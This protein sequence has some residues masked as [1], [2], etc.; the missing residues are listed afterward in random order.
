MSHTL[1]FD[2]RVE[3]DRF[4]VVSRAIAQQIKLIVRETLFIRHSDITIFYSA[5]LNS[6]ISR[7][8]KTSTLRYIRL[9]IVKTVFNRT[10]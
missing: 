1:L 6:F 9:E 2:R 7:R 3:I 4:P 5:Y 10:D 8:D